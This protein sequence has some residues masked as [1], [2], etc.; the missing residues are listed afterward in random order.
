[1]FSVI[2]VMIF[3]KKFEIIKIIRIFETALLVS[4]NPI[5]ILKIKLSKQ[6]YNKSLNL[7]S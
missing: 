6:D 1:M 5:L 7:K 4:K 2:S 3:F